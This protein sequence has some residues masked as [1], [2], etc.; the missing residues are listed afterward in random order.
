MWSVHR[1]KL[2][3]IVKK[4]NFFEMV[5]YHIGTLM[6]LYSRKYAYDTIGQKSMLI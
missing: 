1:C 2:H 4:K 6:W 3:V 5:M